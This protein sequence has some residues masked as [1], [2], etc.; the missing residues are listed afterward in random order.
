MFENAHSLR[1]GASGIGIKAGGGPGEA[2]EQASE[3]VA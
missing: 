3:L 2:G 1:H